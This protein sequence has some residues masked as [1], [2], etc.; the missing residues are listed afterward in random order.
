MPL[1][2]V[3]GDVLEI[4]SE[5]GQRHVWFTHEGLKKEINYCLS[6][7]SQFLT[8]KA[9]HNV[10]GYNAESGVDNLSVTITYR[11]RYAGI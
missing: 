1:E 3:A 7:D 10:F 5:I 6:S 11:M 4:T 2:M 9:G 8:L